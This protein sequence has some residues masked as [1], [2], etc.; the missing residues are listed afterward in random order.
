MGGPR[1]VL[2]KWFRTIWEDLFVLLMASAVWTVVGW[3]PALLF[4]TL[5][6]A[7]LGVIALLIFLPPTTAGVYYVTHRLAHDFVGKLGHFWEGARLYARQAWIFALFNS[8]ILAII[9]ANFQFYAPTEDGP[10]NLGVGDFQLVVDSGA[11]WVIVARSILLT[12]MLVWL[13][14]Q[15]YAFP[16]L[17]EQKEPNVW[18]AMRNSLFIAFGSPLLTIVVSLILL[19]LGVLI[20]F[21][22]PQILRWLPLF[23]IL[24]PIVI[25]LTN[26][27]LVQRL[28]VLRGPTPEQPD[29]FRIKRNR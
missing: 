20:L 2:G 23:L 21:T 4:F 8:L 27:A 18:Y 24:P 10:R 19:A 1:E 13:Y 28:K 29:D 5:G 3:G 26:I 16:M 12:V 9:W 6:L 25:L 14:S 7:P 22:L 11:P 15:L 17:M